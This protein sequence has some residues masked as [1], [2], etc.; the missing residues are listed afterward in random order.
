MPALEYFM[1]TTSTTPAAFTGTSAY[2]TDF[3]NVISRAVAIASLPITQLTN[4]K[5]TLTAQSDELTKLD[6]KFA[7]L[8]TAV[9]ALG[10]ALGGS[11]FQNSVSSPNVVD[12]SVGNGAQE[13][14][15][16]M[17]VSSIGAYESSMSSA[18]WN[19]PEVAK[20]PTTFTLVIGNQN[21][22][23]TGADNSAKSVADAINASY[24]NLVHAT[25]VNVASGDTRISLQSAT[26]GASNLDILNIP[27]SATP[28]SI[29]TQAPTGYA[30]S[31]TTSTWDASGG[32]ANTYTLTIGG[33]QY[34]VTGASNSAADVA[35]AINNDP[36]YGAQVRATVVDLGTGTSHDLRISLQS[37]TAGPMALDLAKAD[38]LSLQTQQTAATSR[39]ATAWDATADAAGSRSTYA[40]VAGATLYAFTPADNSAASV[41]SAINSMYGSQVKASVV[42]FGSSVSHDYRISLQSM[43]G[44]ATT[45]DIQKTTATHYQTEQT[46]GSLATYQVNGS[47]VTNTST[48]RNITISPGVTA[49]LVGTSGG[50]PAG[51][52]PVGITVTRSTSALGSALSGFTDAYNAAVTEVN[53]QRGQSGGA[54][55]GQSI[56]NQLSNLLSS[57]STY[58]SS[59][60]FSGLASLGL[61][62][63]TNGQITYNALTLM[64]ADLTSSTGVTAF[65]GSATGGGFLKTATD[66]LTSVEDS[67]TGLLKTSETDTKSQLAD[68]GATIAAKQAKVDAMQ[69]QMQ[70]QMAAADALVA[71]M[72]QQYSYLSGMFQAQQTA[73]MMYR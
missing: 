42:D 52:T 39:T 17:N 53:G 58:S 63:G 19:V 29:Q 2:S 4:N 48:T 70:N 54:L 22:S 45:F 30:I 44:N 56:V 26:L 33:S 24:G 14:Y 40:L 38:G 7:A 60:Q 34:S 57:I 67:V 32:T 69:L 73:D 25:T 1:G 41:A 64:S 6:T 51:S 3:A 13:G 18:N 31:Q 23:I 62:L 71:S 9:T 66:A 10:A 47:G 27:A 15:Y 43:V 20:Q 46:A 50:T 8:Q 61:D 11:S 36:I 28:T 12:V 59:G 49:T 16:S 55:Q 21:Y 65:L 68:L 37:T 35:D 72:E 5:T